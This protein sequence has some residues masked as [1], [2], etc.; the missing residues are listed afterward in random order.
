MIDSLLSFI[1][2]HSC[3]SCGNVG[4]LLCPVCKYDI[5]DEPFAK[6]LVCLTPTSDSNICKPCRKAHSID[7]AWVVG[8]RETSLKMLIDRYKFNST[9]QAHMICC[10]LLQSRLPLLPADIT[11]TSVP[12]SS[13]N[14]RVRG[15]D[16]VSLIAKRLARQNS[17][18]YQ[19]ILEKT[20]SS[21]QHFKTR[22]ERFESASREISIKK[23]VSEPILLVDDIYTTGATVQ[24]CVR[25]LKQAGAK[26]V[27]VAILA[28]Q[29]LDESGGL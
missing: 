14:R 2:P 13:V 7:D 1:A 3:L 24:T 17:L 15:F 6:C 5:I 8:V 19:E 4:S 10:E 16:H 26:Q 9:K 11:V 20:S 23:A 25:L 29:V 18:F 27:Y 22:T 12:T 28:R 21:T